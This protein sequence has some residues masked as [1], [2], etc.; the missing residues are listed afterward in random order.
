MASEK[1]MANAIRSAGNAAISGRD[2][3]KA[4]I[5]AAARDA[6][7]DREPSEAWMRGMHSPEPRK[8]D[9]RGRALKR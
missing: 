1:N 6:G 9:R 8:L 7:Q 4:A 3:V 5:S 2:V